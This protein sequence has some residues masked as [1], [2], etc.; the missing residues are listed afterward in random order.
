[1]KRPSPIWLLKNYREKLLRR[2]IPLKKT[3]INGTVYYH[4]RGAPPHNPEAFTAL[5]RE[6][7]QKISHLTG[8]TAIDAGANIGSYTLPLA[9]KF[10][11][12]IAFEPD[13]A[14]SNL[15]RLNARVNKLS[16]VTVEELALANEE[17]IMP[18]Y[19]R[20]G[21]ATSL[22]PSHYMLKYDAIKYVRVA[23]LDNF[24][25]IPGSVDFV[26]VDAE[27]L[28]LPILKGARRTITRFRPVLGIEVHCAM[29]GSASSCACD[30]CRY[31]D[32]LGY[33]REVTGSSV[34]P[35]AAHWVWALPKR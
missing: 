25:G 9:R 26:K 29:K 15:L 12:V 35:T 4:M 14:S 11:N 23:R 7:H 21:G 13:P 1:M 31:L 28:E 30:T 20:G 6:F 32:N 22:D 19:V 24:P 2:L 10:R 27:N 18:L 17:G 33:D 34:S 3:S 5:G 8:D 16:N